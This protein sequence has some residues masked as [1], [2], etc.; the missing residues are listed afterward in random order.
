MRQIRGMVGLIAVGLL[1]TGCAARTES[2][3]EPAGP[4]AGSA[5]APADPL[6][7]IG[8]WTITEADEEKGAIL[9]LAERLTLFRACGYIAG[10]WRASADGLFVGHTASGG[11]GRRPGV[12]P[13]GP[14]ASGPGDVT[15][16]GWLRR[17]SG[18]RQDG[19][20]QLLLDEQGE[21]VARL[22]PG[23]RLTPG[24]NLDAMGTAPPV[25]DDDARRVMAPASPVPTNLRPAVR[26]DLPGRWVAAEDL[27]NDAA[28]VEFAPNNEWHGS[29]GCNAQGGRWVFGSAGALLATD[30]PSTMIGCDGMLVGLWLR[31]TYRAGFDGDVLVLLDQTGKEVGRLLRG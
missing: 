21:T 25:V 6:A 8:L 30:G 2:A 1:L 17:V 20:A 18:F 31:H 12:T 16:P 9:R 28:F 24:P 10:T 3:R 14:C 22:V 29:D 11:P 26:S 15:T 13:T 4:T 19:D 7:L 27:W 5:L 23:A